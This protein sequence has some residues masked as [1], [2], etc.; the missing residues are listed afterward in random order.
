MKKSYRYGIDFGTTNSSICIIS[1]EK[2]GQV[3]P[4]VLDV[5]DYS[6]PHELLRSV[7]AYKG[8]DVY[9]GDRG[10]EVVDGNEDNPIRQIK[11]RLLSDKKDTK[12]GYKDTV[13]SDVIAELLSHM[14]KEA[15]RQITKGIRMNGVVMGVPYG[16]PEDVKSVYLRALVKARFFESVDQALR[17][18]EFVEEPV[19][20]AMY[21]GSKIAHQNKY[22]LV[23]D[24]GG[25]TLDMA[26]V[27]L[28]EQNLLHDGRRRP[29]KII[30]KGGFQGAGEHFTELLFKNCF[31]S[32]YANKYF[33]GESW[34]VA[35]MFQKLGCT[36]NNKDG[37]WRNLEDSGIGWK[38]INELDKAKIRLS[39]ENTVE[40][41]FHEAANDEHG[42][43]DFRPITLTR[44]DFETALAPDLSK[45]KMEVENLFKTAECKKS[46]VTKGKIDE[47]LLAGGTS[48][49]PC[50]RKCLE[51]IF[52]GKVHFDRETESVYYINVMTCISQGLALYGFNDEQSL[53]VDDVTSFDYGY[54]DNAKDEIEVIIPKGTPYSEIQKYR[55]DEKTTPQGSPFSR[56][57]QQKDPRGSGFWIDIY[58][59]DRK[60]MHLVFD[61]NDH[62]GYYTLYFSI[63]P[64]TGVLQ[65][66]V[67]DPQYSH[68]VQDLSVEDREWTMTR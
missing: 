47:V 63:D 17:K 24:Y 48:M 44:E 4:K 57:I 65:I 15:D 55:V 31:F 43:I 36:A 66:H 33:Q 50:V 40:F 2:G 13:I 23:F 5:D 14:K 51:E 53:I 46:G 45:I 6:Q 61:K 52:P 64:Y 35:K 37:I 26:I 1:N 42:V 59:G 8:N 29:H 9:I 49:I 25:G 54:Y 62:S 41:T 21:Y 11:L 68:W 22:A 60:I 10:L 18:T 58:E 38:F 56:H 39:T 27:N 34:Q 20:V 67:Y 32:S 16:T 7:I 12:T 3:L 19:A 28:L 30:S